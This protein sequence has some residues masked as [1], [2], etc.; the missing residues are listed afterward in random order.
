MGGVVFLKIVPTK[1]FSFVHCL[2]APD[3]H[4]RAY[5]M[6]LQIEIKT[7]KQNITGNDGMSVLDQTQRTT[8]NFNTIDKHDKWADHKAFSEKRGQV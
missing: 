7:Q 6:R 5:D 4:L 8:T 3:K 2:Q 1:S